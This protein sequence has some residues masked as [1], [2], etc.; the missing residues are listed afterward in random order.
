MLSQ[1]K[2]SNHPVNRALLGSHVS[3]GGKAKLYSAVEEALQYDASAMLVYTGAPHN[4]VRV[5]IDQF[6]VQEAHELMDEKGIREISVHAPFLINLASADDHKWEYS[7]ELF[8]SEVIR[9]S[10]IGAQTFVFHPGSHVG[11][12]S[13]A[14]I[15][16]VI[17]GLNSVLKNLYTEL[18]VDKIPRILIETMAGKGTEV[19]KDFVELATILDGVEEQ[20][21]SNVGICL[22]TCHVFDGGYDLK[23]HYEDV[24]SEFDDRIGL[25]KIGAIHLNDSKF[26]LASHK[27]RHANI[28]LGKIGFETLSKVSND[29]RFVNVPK[30]LET[31]GHG[32]NKYA[33]PPYGEEIAV[34][35]GGLSFDEYVRSERLYD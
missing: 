31:P 23:E 20:Y 19:G 22:D 4:S 25:D 8:T 11:A 12:G 18:P 30:L 9:T 6:H 13:E 24:L 28:G 5:P 7:V 34:L 32:D 1:Q 17:R 29:A 10:A 2:Q 15:D 26:G 33:D 21:R 35:R 14:G 27:D 3:V 16:N